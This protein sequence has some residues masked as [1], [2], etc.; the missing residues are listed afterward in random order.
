MGLRLFVATT[1]RVEYDYSGSGFNYLVS[2]FHDLL[3]ALGVDYSGDTWDERFDVEKDEWLEGISKLK[4]LDCLEASE[5]E[6][7]EKALCACECTREEAIEL[8]VW[9]YNSS[10]PDHDYLEFQFM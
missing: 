8:F 10:A 2:E 3:D 5:R 6:K 9:Y 7:I 4:N 1:Y